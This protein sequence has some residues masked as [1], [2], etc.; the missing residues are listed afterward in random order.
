VGQ[1]PVGASP[2]FAPFTADGRTALVVAQGSGELQLIDAAAGTRSGDIKVGQAPHWVAATSDGR[3]AYVTNE[4][5][6]DVS[7]VDLVSRQVRATIAV[8]NAP[9]K[10]AVQPGPSARAGDP[11]AGPAA[12]HA[13][14]A[15]GAP[16]KL[17]STTFADHGTAEVRGMARVQLT[18]D[19]YYFA[20]TFLRGDP[21]QR[22]TLAVE[23]AS[24]T[25]HSVTIP[26]LQVDRDVPPKG[27][28]ELAVTF[29]ASGV[30][31][32]FC[33]IH[34]ALGMNGELLTGDAVP[35]A[36]ASSP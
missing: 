26:D 33:K 28:V 7:V 18:I 24:S 12:A 20:P 25:L 8:G 4:G 14:P 30:V 13:P 32:L 3:I 10:I 16:L 17:G 31:H 2:H 6:N 36:V 15:P 21:G 9:R 27:R 5:S 22:L 29:P 34:A 11:P 19:D 23:N 1:I 35:Q